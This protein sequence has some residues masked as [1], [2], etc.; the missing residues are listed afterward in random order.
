MMEE[1]DLEPIPSKLRPSP[2]SARF[3]KVV[4]KVA[5]QVSPRWLAALRH[6]GRGERGGGPSWCAAA[7]TLTGCM[8]VAFSNSFKTLRD[9]TDDKLVSPAELKKVKD[10]GNGAF[11]N[12]EM[13]M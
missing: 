4:S 6:R 11:A 7:I 9:M 13:C 3:Q 1:P 12:V 5:A 8:Q 10:L 2:A